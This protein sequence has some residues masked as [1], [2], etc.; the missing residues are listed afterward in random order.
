MNSLCSFR[1]ATLNGISP[2]LNRGNNR[3]F[4]ARSFLGFLSRP[5]LL[6]IDRKVAVLTDT[7][8]V[9]SSVTV[10]A[11]VRLLRS[12]SSVVTILTHAVGIV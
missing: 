6:M 9:K 1:N 10:L 11:L 5:F 2:C 12:S 3:A 4:V 7:L 8:C